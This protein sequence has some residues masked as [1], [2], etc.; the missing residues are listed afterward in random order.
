MLGDICDFY[1]IST[2]DKSPERQLNLSVEMK[3]GRDII[4][5]F[6]YACPKAERYFMLGNHED[7]LRKFLWNNPAINGCI[8][9]KDK[10][11]LNEFN[12][13]VYDYG[14]NFVYKGVLIY[15][16]GNKANKHSGY[17]ARNILDDNG[18]STIFG[19]THRLGKH[20]RTNYS[21]AMVAVENGCLCKMDLSK[22]WFQ[23]ELG[24]WQWGISVVK[25]I[26]DRFTITDICIPKHKFILYGKSYYTLD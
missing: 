21:G 24:N 17:T 18:L 11:G 15:T 2:F 5:K 22:E 7:R 25:F 20:Y 16:H 19:H 10:L 14:E 26:E 9:I 6:V 3:A 1:S 4:E 23:R 13:N 8:D 12:F